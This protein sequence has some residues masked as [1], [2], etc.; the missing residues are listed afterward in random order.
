MGGKTGGRSEVNLGTS[1]GIVEGTGFG[2]GIKRKVSPDT[3][4]MGEPR[5]G[6]TEN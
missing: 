6:C 1:G 3:L 4:R 5:E 2:D